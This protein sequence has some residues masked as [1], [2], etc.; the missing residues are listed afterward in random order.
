MAGG[1]RWAVV[2]AGL[3]AIGAAPA[4]PPAPSDAPP[5]PAAAAIAKAFA[6]PRLYHVAVTSTYP[7]RLD[8]SDMCLGVGALTEMLVKI[9]E[10]PDLVAALGKGCTQTR[11]RAED[12]SRRVETACDQAAGAFTTSRMSLSGTPERI[13]QHT[14]V[15]M[16]LGPSLPKT[17]VMDMV[18]TYVGECPAP[19]KPGQVRS[20]TGVISDP[21][22]GF[23]SPAADA[24]AVK[25]P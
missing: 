25:T 20:A 2:F 16:D 21:L 14:E 9:S 13:H 3:L 19:M 8:G 12:G 18:M 17:V 10:N 6:T 22:A 15:D 11:G 23:A 1:G 5:S 4:P 7:N 24:K